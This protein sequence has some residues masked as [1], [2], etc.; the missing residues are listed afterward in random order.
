MLYE[1]NG[2]LFFG[3]AQAAMNSLEASASSPFQVLVLNLGRVSVI[4]ATGFAALE[5]AIAGVLRRKRSVV[6]A[7]PLPEPKGVFDKARL[8]Q[9]YPGLVFAVDLGRG[10][11]GG[12]EAF[13][14]IAAPEPLCARGCGLRRALKRACRL[15]SDYTAAL[16]HSCHEPY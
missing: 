6:V 14:R 13:A 8:E 7:G 2:P 9:K 3:A 12:G 5:N 1:I 4:D 15:I 11:R 16:M 10:A